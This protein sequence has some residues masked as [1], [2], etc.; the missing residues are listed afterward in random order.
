VAAVI[1]DAIQRFLG[2]VNESR[3]IRLARDAL[4]QALSARN[5]ARTAADKASADL[6][7]VESILSGAADRIDSALSSARSARAAR[8]AARAKSLASGE[9]LAEADSGLAARE[10]EH[11]TALSDAK[12]ERRA[13]EQA[14]EGLQERVEEARL[15]LR[16]A[17]ETFEERVGAVVRA[18]AAWMTKDI[19]TLVGELTA[20]YRTLAAA[21]ECVGGIDQPPL[22]QLQFPRPF[23]SEPMAMFSSFRQ[24]LRTDPEAQFDV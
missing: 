1:V 11:L 4:T 9:E 15:T 23:L 24:R 7:R 16:E 12:L 22:P 17:E 5:A 8:Q 21:D 19:E 10:R 3:D 14:V 2:T 18:Q 20:R 13:A 6:E